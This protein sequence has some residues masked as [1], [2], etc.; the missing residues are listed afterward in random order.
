MNEEKIKAVVDGIVTN[1]FQSHRCVKAPEG[2]LF[3]AGE[4]DA[5]CE[6]IEQRLTNYIRKV[7][8]RSQLR[9]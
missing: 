4:M 2:R 9:D 7:S 5:L 8:R 6:D 3:T 1:T